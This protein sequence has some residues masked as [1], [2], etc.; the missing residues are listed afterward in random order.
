MVITGH[1]WNPS[2]LPDQENLVND[3]HVQS[4]ISGIRLLRRGNPYRSCSSSSSTGLDK[5][6]VS[7]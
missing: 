4:L 1:Q 7:E 2:S 6:D 3:V 5:S